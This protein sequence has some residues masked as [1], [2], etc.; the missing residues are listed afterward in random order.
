[1]M[2]TSSVPKALPATI[3]I[4]V[5]PTAVMDTQ[6]EEMTRPRGVYHAAQGERRREGK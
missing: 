4:A 1:M 6:K 2:D 3:S 5:D